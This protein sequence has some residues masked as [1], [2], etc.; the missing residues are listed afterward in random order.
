MQYKVQKLWEGNK[1][2]HFKNVLSN[3]KTK[4]GLFQI[5][6]AFSD[7]LNFKMRYNQ[8]FMKIVKKD[9]QMIFCRLS[10]KSSMVAISKLKGVQLLKICLILAWRK[11]QKW[12]LPYANGV[13]HL[14]TDRHWK[15]IF[16]KFCSSYNS[17]H[18]NPL[19]YRVYKDRWHN[20]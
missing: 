8:F 14:E 2:H 6:V 4:W 5:F 11:H 12:W 15:T 10:T 18:N 3:V 16:W 1:L 20:R 13:A 19:T 7:Y 9:S 17:C